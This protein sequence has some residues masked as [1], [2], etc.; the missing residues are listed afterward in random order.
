MSINV[1]V[2]ARTGS[3]SEN[4]IAATVEPREYRPVEMPLP[5]LTPMMMLDSAIKQGADID[6]LQKLM[7]LQERWEKTQA[8]KAF[9]E[10]ISADERSTRNER[11]N[12]AL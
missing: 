6:V 9:D 2:A 7:D 1:A 8:R 3:K 4:E 5:T 12:S 11:K 10:A